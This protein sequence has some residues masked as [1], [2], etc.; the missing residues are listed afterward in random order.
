VSLHHLPVV[1]VVTGELDIANAPAIRAAL[2]GAE[3]TGAAEIVLDLSD[4]TFMGSVGLRVIL[5]A[6]ARARA[7][8]RRL[9]LR[10]SPAEPPSPP[11]AVTWRAPGA[12]TMTRRVAA[13][14]AQAR[15]Q[16]S[17][18]PSGGG[19]A[20]ER[21]V[22]SSGGTQLATRPGRDDLMA[23]MQ[24]LLA[25][26]AGSTAQRRA[27]FSRPGPPRPPSPPPHARAHQAWPTVQVLHRLARERSIVAL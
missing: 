10:V 15:R 11:G 1:I 2:L 23:K 25:T 21:R 12:G 18:R 7:A 17:S 4:L 13:Q 3:A 6:D 8:G 14:R 27:T 9:T 16:G 22:G 19:A 26:P 24:R 5:E 20:T